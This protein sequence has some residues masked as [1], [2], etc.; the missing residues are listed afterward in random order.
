MRGRSM[1]I[2]I[3][4]VVLC[5]STIAIILHTA[6]S[7]PANLVADRRIP[8]SDIQVRRPQ[9]ATEADLGP[10]RPV[11][12]HG[13]MEEAQAIEIPESSSSEPVAIDELPEDIR[14]ETRKVVERIRKSVKGFPPD[15]RIS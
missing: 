6:E 10:R 15:P 3:V 14:E 13:V 12:S 4:G 9:T 5:G 11:V 1:G 2:L 7:Q 8:E